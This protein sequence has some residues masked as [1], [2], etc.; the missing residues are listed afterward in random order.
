MGT[1][2]IQCSRWSATT[3][4]DHQRLRDALAVIDEEGWNG[5]TGEALLRF[6]RR[7]LVRPLVRMH[8]LQGPRGAQAEATGWEQAWIELA[9]PKLRT[10][11]SPWAVVWTRVRRAVIG[12]WLGG[13]YCV[14]PRRAWEVREHLD[15]SLR[16][17]SWKG[18]ES[19]ADDHH[20]ARTAGASATDPRLTTAVVRVLVR[21]GWDAALAADVVDAVVDRLSGP[22]S[23]SGA[24]NGARAIGRELGIPQWQVHRVMVLILGAPGWTGVAE[25]IA[26]E[27]HRVLDDRAIVSAAR[28]TMHAWHKSPVYEARAVE[29]QPTY[30]AH[31]CTS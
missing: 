19:L 7:D 23:R 28:S 4:R 9:D 5:P 12:E 2:L 18:L 25:R 27:G 15:R 31:R 8:G 20:A 11:H 17:S 21:V 14:S 29:R 10:A 13:E 24:R 3:L 16:E 26:V 6:V 30:S 22:P 1:A